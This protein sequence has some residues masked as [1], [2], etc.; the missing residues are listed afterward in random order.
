MIVRFVAGNGEKQAIVM[1]RNLCGILFV[2]IGLAASC[3]AQTT[4]SSP[5]DSGLQ[6]VITIGPVPDSAAISSS[7]PLADKPFVVKTAGGTVAASFTTDAEGRFEVPLTPGHYVIAAENPNPKAGRYGP[8][9]VDVVAGQ[10][11]SVTWTCDSGM[12]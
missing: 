3:L 12:R 1:G 4:S 11:K 10:M 8:F 5:S 7:K 6:G 2:V 9:E